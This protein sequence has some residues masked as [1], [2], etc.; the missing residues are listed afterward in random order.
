LQN[1]IIMYPHPPN[2]RVSVRERRLIVVQE[3]E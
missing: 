1:M 2:T 3:W